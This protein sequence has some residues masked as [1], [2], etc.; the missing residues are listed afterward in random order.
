MSKS[1]K[2]VQSVDN[3]LHGLYNALLAS[4]ESGWFL[5]AS[6]TLEVHR[7]AEALSGAQR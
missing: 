6:I 1:V 5:Q 2:S 7:Q 4:M 3:V